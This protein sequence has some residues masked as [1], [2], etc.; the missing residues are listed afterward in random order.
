[1]KELNVKLKKSEAHNR[2]LWSCSGQR[3][4]CPFP[5]GNAV[6]QKGSN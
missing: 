2:E 4:Q 5:C 3:S 1:L 6:H